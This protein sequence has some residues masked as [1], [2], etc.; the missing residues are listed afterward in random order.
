LPVGPAGRA[1]AALATA[2]LLGAPCLARAD[3][4]ELTNG[5]RIVGRVTDVG[6]TGVRIETDGGELR[7][8][9]ADVRSIAF[10]SA[11]PP[12]PPAVAA[13]APAAPEPPETPPAVA[14]AEPR[15]PPI[16]AA[17]AALERLHAATATPLPPDDYAARVEEVRRAATP[18]FADA[19]ARDEFLRA[20]GA[21]LRYHAFAALASGVDVARDDLTALGAEPLVAECRALRELVARETRRPSLDPRDPSVA[22]VFTQGQG[23]LA[24]RTCAGEQIVEARRQAGAPR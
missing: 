1:I 9:Q 24:L 11:P 7:I 6:D 4:V 18:A 17:L 3:V 16:D 15:L 23:A 2:W 10:G 21:A 13:P 8:P 5:R 22:V 19:S 12:D 20:V 14:V